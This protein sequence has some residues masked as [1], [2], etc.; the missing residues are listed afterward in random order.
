MPYTIE[1]SGGK[2]TSFTLYDHGYKIPDDI[3]VVRRTTLE[4]KR[5]ALVAWLKAS[6]QGWTENLA[7]PAAY[8]PTFADTW[9]EGTGRTVENESSST[10]PRSR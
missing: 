4:T 7:N 8:P 3:V 9:F 6:R 10:P 5:D 1:Q 2:A